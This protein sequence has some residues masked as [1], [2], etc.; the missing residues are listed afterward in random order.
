MTAILGG[1]FSHVYRP[2]FGLITL[3]L[4]AEHVKLSTHVGWILNSVLIT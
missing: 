1:I 4:Y 2:M 3:V